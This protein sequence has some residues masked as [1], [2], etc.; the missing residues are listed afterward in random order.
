M[1]EGDEEVGFW[2]KNV[3]HTH[4]RW[5]TRVIFTTSIRSQRIAIL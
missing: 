4:T 1:E 5:S 2:A 3:P